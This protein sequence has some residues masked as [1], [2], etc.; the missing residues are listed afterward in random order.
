M[1]VALV[2]AVDDEAEHGVVE[3][4]WSDSQILKGSEV[5][6]VNPGLVAVRVYPSPG[7]SIDR[8]E[9]AATPLVALTVKVP[10][11]DPEP[12]SDPMATVTAAVEPRGELAVSI[13]DLDLDRTTLGA[14][15]RG[16]H[17]VDGGAGRLAVAGERQRA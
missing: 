2:V 13:Q 6:G 1:T 3:Q 9:N 10:D 14:D 4:C 17:R 15:G 8:S 7:W 5:A 16:D 11:S 12:G